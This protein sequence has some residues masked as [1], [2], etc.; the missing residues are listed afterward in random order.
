MKILYITEYVGVSRI[1]NGKF[2]LILN[3][4]ISIHDHSKG[5]IP[6]DKLMGVKTQKMENNF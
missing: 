1:Y 4:G 3:E 2:N 6:T 5:A